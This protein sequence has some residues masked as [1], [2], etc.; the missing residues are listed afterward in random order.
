MRS[1]MLVLVG[2][3]FG[4]LAGAG[5]FEWINHDHLESSRRIAREAEGSANRF[6]LTAD[7]AQ[8]DLRFA[9][10]RITFNEDLHKLTTSIAIKESARFVR[11]WKI[12][13][14]T[15]E[16]YIKAVDPDAYRQYDEEFLSKVRLPSNPSHGE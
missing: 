11:Y 5:V 1:A 14:K 8:E 16:D 12:R 10:K 13:A 2:V 15:A 6:R 7:A 4:F 3:V 9:N